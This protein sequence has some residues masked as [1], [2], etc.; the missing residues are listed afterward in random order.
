MITKQKIIILNQLSNGDRYITYYANSDKL[1][2]FM[3]DKEDGSI[4]YPEKSIFNAAELM[5]IG[6]NLV[7][8]WKEN[9]RE[10]P[11]FIELNLN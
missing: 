10:M 8:L 3:L 5:N 7:S 1:D 6:K 11:A 2:R 9:P 4:M